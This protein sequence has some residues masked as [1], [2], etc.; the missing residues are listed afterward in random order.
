MTAVSTD[1]KGLGNYVEIE[2]QGGYRTRYVHLSEISVKP[3][4]A[5]SRG[6]RIGASGISG[7]SFAPHLH[8]EVIRDSLSL[9]PT[10][11]F[12]AD[13]SPTA[14]SNLLYMAERTG[15]SLD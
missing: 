1:R 8:Y 3:G 13:L 6:D 5:V 2:H 12:F 9:E 11:F 4:Q 14:Y 7:N 15:Q 10:A